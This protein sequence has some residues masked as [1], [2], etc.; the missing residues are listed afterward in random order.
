MTDL[1]IAKQQDDLGFGTDKLCELAVRGLPAMFDAEE[2]LFSYRVCH[3]KSGLVRE[4]I[5]HRY[6]IM[7]LLGLHRYVQ[8]G[9]RV[10]FDME[11]IFSSLVQN[12]NWINNVGDAG[13][14]L[15]LTAAAFPQY[16]DRVQQSVDPVSS[17]ERHAKTL[18]TMEL[19][20]F[21][22]GCSHMAI[23]GTRS[24]TGSV[25]VALKAY[26]ML[27]QNQGDSGAFGHQARQVGLKGKLRG[28]MGSFADQVY[29]IYAM[30]RM[31]QAYGIDE[32][33]S[34]ALS[35]AE[36]ICGA[37]GELGQWWW[38]YDS[39]T[40]KVLGRYPVYS[41]HQHG[42]APMALFALQEVSSGEWI[43]HIKRGLRWIVGTNELRRDL[44]DEDH[45]LVWRCV[46]PTPTF[47]ANVEDVAGIFGLGPSR[48]TASNLAV[49]RECRPYESG[50]LLYAFAGRSS[51]QD[52][53]NT[54]TRGMAN[55]A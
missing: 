48:L 13:L 34:R 33:I 20:W 44:R 16:L 46:R 18:N 2:G 28:R 53:S 15:W 8:T 31:A 32:P 38:H 42:M 30:S 4:G 17:L 50:W 35:C 36:V 7:T 5:S 51:N 40:G 10:A 23:V 14:L 29:P 21:L 55:R 41:V 25:D 24:G 45:Q 11:E 52:F 26:R 49:L 39:E 54:Y 19:A 37:Q 47:L 27:L 43:D 22:T 12:I 1:K 9:G 6:T 3:T